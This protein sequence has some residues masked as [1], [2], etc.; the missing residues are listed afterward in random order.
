MRHFYLLFSAVLAA[1]AC[2]LCAVPGG[3]P[4]WIS[5]AVV[6]TVAFGALGLWVDACRE[7]RVRR[8]MWE[9]SRA[10]RRAAAADE[11]I[12]LAGMRLRRLREMRPESE[13]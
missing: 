8:K 3:W 7:Y 9:R 10:W 1:L 13:Q 6:I 2:W 4:V 5:R 11:E 12:S